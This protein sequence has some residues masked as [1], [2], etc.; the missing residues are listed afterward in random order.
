MLVQS[1]VILPRQLPPNWSSCF[2]SSL[3]LVASSPHST[4]SHL[5]VD[6]VRPHV[7]V[8]SGSQ[9]HLGLNSRCL[10]LQF[11]KSWLLHT[12]TTSLRAPL[13]HSCYPPA[14][15]VS[16]LLFFLDGLCCYFVCPECSS[17]ALLRAGSFS[18]I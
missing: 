6:Q 8:F 5:A 7:K 2:L 3:S 9:S 18:L 10:G 11:L 15:L 14:I 16:F 1:T 12:C 13:P 4:V 17:L